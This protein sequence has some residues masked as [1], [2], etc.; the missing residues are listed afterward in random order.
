MSDL[1]RKV[2]EW[3]IEEPA[4]IPPKREKE[5][6]QREPQKAPTREVPVPVKVP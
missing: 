2:R 6:P 1:G 5:S 4:I 3:E